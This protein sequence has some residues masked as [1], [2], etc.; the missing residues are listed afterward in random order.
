MKRLFYYCVSKAYTDQQYIVG[1]ENAAHHG[2]I[3]YGK[4]NVNTE[5][6]RYF[7]ANVFQVMLL[8][9]KKIQT[10]IQKSNIISYTFLIFHG[11][12]NLYLKKACRRW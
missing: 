10:Q 6:L 8:S 5:R 7:I 4:S 2:I 1:L 3:H 9:N 12:L 11:N